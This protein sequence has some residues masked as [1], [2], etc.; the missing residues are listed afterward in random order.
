MSR[1]GPI[2]GSEVMLV[3]NSVVGYLIG[4]AG[5]KIIELQNKSG[6]RIQ[7]GKDS[8]HDPATGMRPIYIAGEHINIQ[9]AKHFINETVAEVIFD[10]PVS[11][12][13]FHRL[14]K[15]I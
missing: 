12:S 1:T 4:K 5:C 8:E 9:Y 7:A 13:H 11:L 10:R 15:N 6:A 2:P 3:P 14:E